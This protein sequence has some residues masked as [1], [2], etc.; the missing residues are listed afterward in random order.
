MIRLFK[1]YIPHSVLLLWLIDVFLL[2]AAN[3]ISWRLRTEQIGMDPGVLADRLGPHAAFAAVIVLSMISVGV[4]GTDA[5][6]S[7]R[8]AAARLLVAVSLGV[9]ALSFVDFLFAGQHFW[10][11]TLA[12]SMAIGIVRASVIQNLSRNIA[13]EWPA[14]LS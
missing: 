10:R 14:C 8:F 6:R 7:M 13:T 4:Y 2:F 12:Y 3:E 9:I 1:H 5:L 11:S